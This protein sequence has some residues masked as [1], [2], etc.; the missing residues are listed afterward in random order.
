MCACIFRGSPH[1]HMLVW[2]KNPPKI[3]WENAEAVAAYVDEHISCALP[4][5]EDDEEKSELVKM[6]VN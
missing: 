5:P 3:D 6:Q 4:S 1:A 2:T